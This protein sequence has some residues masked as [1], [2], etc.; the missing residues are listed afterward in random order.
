MIR[1][2]ESFAA[3]YE[4]VYRELYRFAFCMMGNTHDAEDAVSEAVINAYEHMEG[5]K[6]QDSF[7]SWI[8]SI[9]VNV[10]KKKWRQQKKER[11]K[12]EMSFFAREETAPDLEQAADISNA[13]AMLSEEERT[14]VGYSVFGGYQSGEIGKALNRNPSTVRSIRARAL[15]KMGRILKD[16][17]KGEEIHGK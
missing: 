9:L 13:F 5:L 12:E 1:N 14:I 7:K 15:E 8:F 4:D 10:C 2:A 17:G 16:E 6:S 11:E 3:M